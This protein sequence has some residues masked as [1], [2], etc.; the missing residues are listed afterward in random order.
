MNKKEIEIL[1]SP[2]D[3]ILNY[4]TKIKLHD[5]IYLPAVLTPRQFCLDLKE[6]YFFI[7]DETNVNKLIPGTLPTIDAG[8]LPTIDAGTLPTIYGNK[9]IPGT[10]STIYGVYC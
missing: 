9:C 10:L 1:K 5:S 3:C 4:Y 2:T 7:K 8:T 6:Q